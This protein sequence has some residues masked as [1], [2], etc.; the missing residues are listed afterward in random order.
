[1]HWFDAARTGNLARLKRFLANGQKVDERGAGGLTAL[2]VAAGNGKTA[3]VKLLL[4]HRANPNLHFKRTGRPLTAAVNESKWD[5]AAALVEAGADPNLAGIAADVIVASKPKLLKLMLKRGLDPDGDHAEYGRYL[6][7]AMNADVCLADLLLDAGADVRRCEKAEGESIL[8]SAVSLADTKR[9]RRLV[10]LGADV[11]RPIDKSDGQTALMWVSGS[12]APFKKVAP[13]IRLLVEVG[14]DVNRKDKSGRTA[15]NYAEDGKQA[16]TVKL[17]ASLGGKPGKRRKPAYL[18][19]KALKQLRQRAIARDP[20]AQGPLPERRGTSRAEGQ[21]E[22][23]A[24]RLDG[25][26]PE[27][28]ADPID[29]RFRTRVTQLDV[30][31]VLTGAVPRPRDRHAIILRLKGQA[32]SPFALSWHERAF[33]VIPDRSYPFVRNAADRPVVWCGH[34]GREN[35]TMLLLFEQGKEALAFETWGQDYGARSI[36]DLDRVER[37]T[38]LT[39]RKYPRHGWKQH[40]DPNQT[41]QALVREQD[42][43]LP[44]LEIG[45]EGPNL[46]LQVYPPDV[47]DPANIE[48]IVLVTF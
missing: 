25:G 46:D 28:V 24:I 41:L 7:C 22:A 14:A 42:A 11:N 13:V 19:P 31:A 26:V 45:G 40:A 48:S 47:L 32:W 36:D 21:W 34:Y 27:D 38:R 15:I 29:S 8:L 30:A 6:A 23:R 4:K 20:L 39:G 37:L 43:Y 1:M 33:G 9:I 44:Q 3:A 2:L 35:L 10:K 16:R 12:G 18:D 5:T 17:L